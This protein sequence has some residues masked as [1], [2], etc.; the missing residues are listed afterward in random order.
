MKKFI[1][2]LPFLILQLHLCSQFSNIVFNQVE[3]NDGS[4]GMNLNMVQDKKG[5]IWIISMVS[6][7]QRYDGY[8]FVSFLDSVYTL[9]D[10]Y[11]SKRGFLVDRRGL[12]WFS[13]IS[14]DLK[15]CGITIFNPENEKSLHFAPDNKTTINSLNNVTDIIEDKKGTIW[16][17]TRDGLLKLEP[18]TKDDFRLQ[19]EIFTKGI[20]SAFKVSIYRPNLTNMAGNENRLWDVF[21]DNQERLW[22]GSQ[23]GLFI[24]NKK[25]NEFIRID[26]YRYGGN[27]ILNPDVHCIVEENPDVIWIVTSGGLCRLSNLNKAI[28][29]MGVDETQIKFKQF[30]NMEIESFLTDNLDHLWIATVDHGLIQVKTGENDKP[31]FK[32]AYADINTLNGENYSWVMSLMKDRTGLIIIGHYYS[33]LRTVSP[34]TDYFNTYAINC[35][36]QKILEDDNGNLWFGTMRK[37]LFKL[38]MD[39][40]LSNFN[41]TDGEVPK[42]D[43]NNIND[44]LEINKGI[45]WLGTDNGIWEFNTKTRKVKK[46][47]INDRKEP[48]YKYVL[49]FLK[50]DNYILISTDLGGITVYNQLTNNLKQY[51]Y[52]EN[53]TMRFTPDRAITIC[54]MKNGD[55]YAGGFKGLCRFRLDKTT[56]E[57]HFLPIENISS[58]VLGELGEIYVLY[59]SKESNLWCGTSNGLFELNTESGETHHWG[60]KDGLPSEIIVSILEDDR[61]NL[62]LGTFS[63]LTMLN[64]ESGYIKVFNESN[65]LQLKLHQ[66]LAAVKS[67]KGLFAFGGIGGFYSFHPDSIT[68]NCH[69]PPIVICDFKL[70]NKSIG[71]DSGKKAIL[72]RNISYTKEIELNHNQNDLSFSFAALD[73]TSPFHNKYAYKLEGYQDEWIETDANNRIAKYTNLRPRTYVFK[74]KGSN[75][76]GVWNE[77]G[78]SLTI[79]IHKPWYGT[80]LAWCIYIVAFLITLGGFIRWRLWRLKKEK[81]ELERQVV[82]RTHQIE[83]QKEEILTQ[84]DMLEVQN[85]KITEHEQLKS[86][87]F[88]NVSHEFRT[89]L[90]LIQS[91]VEEMLDD[92]H[93][94]QKQRR[95]L[96]M[97]HRNARRLLN[98][99]NQLLDISKLD[100]SKMKLELA[101]ADVINHLRAITGAF[102]S[103]A[104]TKSIHYVCHFPKDEIK[105]WF[106]PDKLEKIASNL[107][108]NAFKFTP[109]GGEIIFTA[110]YK[111]SN[112]PRIDRMLEFSVMDSGRGIPSGSLEKIFDRFYQ[113]EESMKSEGG[114]TGIGLSL[115]R[116]MARLQRGD[117]SVVSEPGKG[118]T[119]SVSLPL[120]KNHLKV[121]EFILLK[122]APESIV[123]IPDL[124]DTMEEIVPHQ[125][126]ISRDEKPIL[127]IVEDNR[128]IRM[129]LA[130]NF[131]REYII[132]EA[133]DGVAGL[134]KAT[135]MIPDLVITDLMMPRMDGV[136]L[137]EKLKNDE[138]T[139][140]I[141]VIMLTAK[142]TLEDK[143]SG[144]L[145][146]ADD[147]IPKPFHMAELKARVA[148]LIELRRKLRERFSREV[149]LEPSDISITP[150]DEKFLN[151]A[152]EVVEKHIDD[153]NFDLAE[154]REEVNMTRSTL[155]RKLH[156]LTGQSPTEFI[157]TIRLKRAANLLKQH[158]GNVT[159]ISLEVGFNNL[160]Y[161]NRSFKKLFGVPPNE[162]AKS[163]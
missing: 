58:A 14:A 42:E 128:D 99:V 117:I 96:N 20:S 116:D 112:D 134:K 22:I 94:N 95:K 129:Q 144:Y 125:E 10:P 86:R 145:T 4:I 19:Q 100:G 6:G 50:I 37:G 142:V 9:D 16:C 122:E 36:V 110:L 161:F 13:E 44:I 143:I 71:V 68:T 109:E 108:S 133:V 149:T 67:G 65:G 114:G 90:S 32:E 3:K 46:L 35:I 82:L 12:L 163:I 97:V 124:Q 119:F 51:T 77:E 147:Y 70:F 55:L 154:L 88:T 138:R 135:E 78:T 105:T 31:E 28:R 87:F 48:F 120:G 157:R 132:L 104:E 2:I 127:L 141:P 64:P 30:A 54:E 93:S 34:E 106:D 38:T 113:V 18:E 11:F 45:L 151:R 140:H 21:E 47:F 41:I 123:Y 27:Q 73:Y 84:K 139:C 146:G 43:G 91:P 107:L 63:Y 98:L 103:L 74:V 39:G 131:N 52:N 40:S 62:W 83:E 59:N 130:D 137:C 49:N 155:F 69:V 80:N 61:N 76:D 23:Q 81:L 33:A 101:E 79:I 57:I 85:Q 29:D 56:G 136:E 150:M 72:K 126:G 152:I 25:S 24:F 89:P 53:D 162:Y 156:A 111:N 26:K 15:Y 92:P 1:L 7:L 60:K 66:L 159:Q 118:S 75:N 17:T 121:S 148:N 160:S 153:E 115:A 8:E 5:F 102:T 158:F